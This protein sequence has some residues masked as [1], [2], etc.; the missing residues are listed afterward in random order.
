MILRHPSRGRAGKQGQDD[1]DVAYWGAWAVDRMVASHGP[2]KALFLQAGAEAALRRI[3][4]TDA[5][6]SWNA[7]QRASMALEKLG[8]KTV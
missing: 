7:M 4:A 8:L 6:T 3:L 1:E 5:D 2:N